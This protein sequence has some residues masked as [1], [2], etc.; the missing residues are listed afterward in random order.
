MAT[1]ID[2][3]F[4]ERCLGDG[5]SLP[6]IGRVVGKA[7]GT[8]GYWVKRHGLVAN[9]SQQFRPGK[10][11]RIEPLRSLVKDGL[12]LGQIAKELEVGI[13]SVRYWIAKYELPAPHEVRNARR[14]EQLRSGETRGVWNCRHHGETEFFADNSG[15]WRCRLC[16]Q[17]A[18]SRRRRKV[19]RILVNE[20]GGGC[21]ICGYNRCIGA[22]QFH[23]IDPRNKRFSVSGKGYTISLRMARQEAAKC[24]LLC[25]N[26]HVEVEAGVTRLPD[27]S[28]EASEM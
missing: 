24:A 11:L 16:R 22:L 4:L 6:E 13:A 15:A 1:G 10:G 3:A 28:E 21:F 25:A 19:K 27:G 9:G 18:V 5:M 23:H 7:P 12:T 26:C 17:E 20:A 2:K 14:S 8:V